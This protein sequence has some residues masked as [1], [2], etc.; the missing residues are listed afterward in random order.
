MSQELSHLPIFL[1][2]KR[3]AVPERLLNRIIFDPLSISTSKITPRLEPKM[4]L[5]Q[6]NHPVTDK[7][8][9]CNSLARGE[10]TIQTEKKRKKT[11]QKKGARAAR[12]KTIIR[13][14]LNKARD[15]IHD[16]SLLMLPMF[17]VIGLIVIIFRF[18]IWATSWL[19]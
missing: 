19:F 9:L 6:E 12:V 15:I 3:I 14:K 13:G 16:V 8:R 4:P 7:S 11:Y 5:S 1:P 17:L 10:Q 18:W 2:Q